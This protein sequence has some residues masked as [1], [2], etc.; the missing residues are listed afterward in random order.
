MSEATL[1]VE[2]AKEIIVAIRKLRQDYN[3][4]AKVIPLMIIKA[5]NDEAAAIIAA[6][7]HLILDVAHINEVQLIV[8]DVGISFKSKEVIY[9]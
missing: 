3:I 2:R 6:G 9:D 1:V 5:A 8:K 7:M 4:G